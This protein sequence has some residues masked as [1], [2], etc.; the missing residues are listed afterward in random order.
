MFCSVT[1]Y[2]EFRP[3][4]VTQIFNK[5]ISYDLTGENTYSDIYFQNF[6]TDNL[7][8]RQTCDLDHKYMGYV[9]RNIF[10]EK[11]VLV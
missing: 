8:E 4:C 6:W 2:Y 1:D 3:V 7:K 9:M 10:I 11:K 5:I